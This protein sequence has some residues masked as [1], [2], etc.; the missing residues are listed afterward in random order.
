MGRGPDRTDSG[1]AGI[2]PGPRPCG[3]ARTPAATSATGWPAG[4]EF[5]AIARFDGVGTERA[6]RAGAVMGLN[7]TL[8]LVANSRRTPMS[9]SLG[10][11]GLPGGHYRWPPTCG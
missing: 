9:R 2:H 4:D 8:T 6:A 3:L 11:T 1:S 10:K 5:S 7:P